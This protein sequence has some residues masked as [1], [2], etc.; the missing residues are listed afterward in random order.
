[1]HAINV[2]Q[3]MHTNNHWWNITPEHLEALPGLLFGT[4]KSATFSVHVHVDVLPK[5]PR[6]SETLKKNSKLL[7]TRKFGNKTQTTFLLEQ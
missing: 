2:L 1:M 6:N 7:L 4:L 5:I 3:Y